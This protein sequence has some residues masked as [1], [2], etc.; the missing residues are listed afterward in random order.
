MRTP[1]HAARQGG[2][3]FAILRAGRVHYGSPEEAPHHSPRP[4]SFARTPGRGHLAL[5]EE[6]RGAGTGGE[7]IDKARAGLREAVAL[8]LDAES[9]R[10][11]HSPS[12]ADMAAGRSHTTADQLARRAFVHSPQRSAPSCTGRRSQVTVTPLLRK[13][14]LTTHIILSVGWI[15]AVA[16]YLVLVVNAMASPETH[17]LRGAWMAMDL[18]GR[19]V[20]VPAAIA[21]VLTGLVMSLA[22]PWGL[23]RHS[24]VL[25]SFVL[26]CF[27]A[28]VLLQHMPTVVAFG[29]LAAAAAGAEDAADLRNGLRGEVL[30]AGV[31]LLLLA[32]IAALNVYKP[33]GLTAY[34]RRRVAQDASL[35]R[36]TSPP[37]P[38]PGQESGTRTPVWVWV[39]GGHAFGLAAL[40]AILHIATGGLGHH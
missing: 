8:V 40:L 36:G 6:R 28:V 30:H 26:T 18:I 27:A 3:P 29:R 14:A 24:W 10:A 23:F 33:P 35:A 37:D 25:V 21:T 1:G 32:G 19:Y 34:G 38:V 16:A 4:P 22:T 20:I 12:R 17:T 39:V 15:G 11:R 7:T 2:I 13:F 5:A 31:G 9:A